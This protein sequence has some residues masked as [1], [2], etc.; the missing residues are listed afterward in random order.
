MYIWF[1]HFFH[2]QCTILNLNLMKNIG[3]FTG[4]LKKVNILRFFFIDQFWMAIKNCTYLLPPFQ[5][6]RKPKREFRHKNLFLNLTVGIVLKQTKIRSKKC[7]IKLDFLHSRTF[8]TR[9]IRVFGYYP[10]R[11]ITNDIYKSILTVLALSFVWTPTS[12]NSLN[13]PLSLSNEIP[14]LFTR[15]RLCFCLKLNTEKRFLKTKMYF[16]KILNLYFK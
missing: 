2:T 10:T 6:K 13:S 12:T 15:W 14:L 4:S 1:S 16:W 3:N 9:K 8:K 5:V 11:I 7:K